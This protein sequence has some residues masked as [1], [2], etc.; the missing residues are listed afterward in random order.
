MFSFVLEGIIY[1]NP[2]RDRKNDDI[3][4]KKQKITN[5]HK[6]FIVNNHRY[7]VG[8]DFYFCLFEKKNRTKKKFKKCIS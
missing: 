5:I 1:K 8:I 4:K 2:N 3:T 6:L 7:S